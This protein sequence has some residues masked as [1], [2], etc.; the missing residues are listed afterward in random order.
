M[1]T[2]YHSSK[3]WKVFIQKSSETD[4]G[5]IESILNQTIP[6]LKHIVRTF[7]TYTNHDD[8]HSL[9]I[10]ENYEMLLGE[11][12]ENLSQTEACVLLLSAFW[13]DLGMV[14]NDINEISKEPWYDD[15]IKGNPEN[16]KN[17]L[18]E[19]RI[20]EYIRWNHHNRL[21]K[22]IY[23]GNTI[24]KQEE[25]E[26]IVDGINVIDLAH[27]VS[28]SHNLDSSKTIDL[29]HYSNSNND[30][31]FCAIL[32]RLADIMDFDND[33][34]PTS[35]YKFLGLDKPKNSAEEYSQHE[36]QKHLD[37]S[38]FEYKD[39][40]LYFKATPNDPNIE[41]AIR[42]FIT[43]IDDE[44]EKCK[45]IF[46]HY[47]PKWNILITLPKHIDVSNIHSI[48]YKYGDY[49]F[50]FD[51][52]QTLSLLTGNNIYSNPAIFIRELLQ[53]AIDASMYREALEKGKGI[54]NFKCQPIY[55][56]DWYDDDDGNYWIR[57]DD[58]GIGMD[59]YIILNYFT[60]IGKSF[61]ESDDFDKQTGFKAISRFGIG[62]LSCF[63]ASSRIE[64]STKKEQ[65]EA[66]RFTIKSLDSYFVTRFE[67]LH[68]NIEAFPS[69][70]HTRLKYRQDIG[71]S[72]AIMIDFNKINAWFDIKS[73][74]EKHIFYS[75]IE[76]QYKNNKIAT[77][78]NELDSNP[79]VND[80]TIVEFTKE[81]DEKLKSFFNIDDNSE[82]IKIKITPI[83]L[84][85][86]SPTPKIKAQMVLLEV[87]GIPNPYD[88]RLEFP[89][90]RRYPELFQIEFRKDTYEKRVEIELDCYEPFKIF[91]K[92]NKNVVAHNGI[93]VAEDFSGSFSENI[94]SFLYDTKFA[95]AHIWLQDEY[96]P[97]MDISRSNEVYFDFNTIVAANLLLS[98]FISK[99]NLIDE[100]Y[101][102]SLLYNRFDYSLT[103]EEVW[104]NSLLEEW[105]IEPLFDNGHFISLNEIKDLLSVN[106]KVYI[107]NYPDINHLAVSSFNKSHTRK[108]FVSI[109]IQLFTDGHLTRE[110]SYVITRVYEIKK[111]LENH[112]YFPIGFFLEYD[113]GINDQLQLSL[114][115]SYIKFG[116]NLNHPFSMWL[117]NNAKEL[118]ENYKGLF[119]DI[120]AQCVRSSIPENNFVRLKELLLL[121]QKLEPNLIDNEIIQ[122]I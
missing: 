72:I 12:I 98:R 110:G 47:C 100:T 39:S 90:G 76:I 119:E 113:P 23:D 80:I 92:F 49:K 20:S 61:Y 62:I 65:H 105:I 74:L 116:L 78:L 1:I 77:T 59:E 3:L 45:D 114:S 9:K 101:D 18:S 81:D 50:S 11:K 120:K 40:V 52:H 44:L 19:N 63:M 21:E 84:S 111:A 115:L 79:W 51:N 64:V 6:I 97:T 109:L 70:D 56:T 38:P 36:W 86:K 69:F 53:N 91:K 108:L 55:I 73:E 68:R 17:K 37:N 33:R 83:D 99:N 75:P 29:N 46:T 103:I 117:Y 112:L 28:L 8:Q 7:P 88:I 82:R 14:C 13:H 15:Y 96:R 67:S 104:K 16:D 60:K 10:I 94:V 122:S 31:I 30:F 93:I 102:I 118:A 106:E 27:K 66:I 26:L 41:H 35:I 2:D 87:V 71:T 107:F 89:T 42:T 32:L 121:L 58:D 22:Y 25:K 5:K 85:K 34:A 54:T 43:V 95:L 57:F 4:H 48:G 24:L